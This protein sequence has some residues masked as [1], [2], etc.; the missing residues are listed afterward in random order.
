MN[1]FKGIMW[2]IAISAMLWVV[3]I[4]TSMA[5]VHDVDWRKERI[6]KRAKVNMWLCDRALN[7]MH[8]SK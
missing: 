6:E 3:I 5:I 8:T 2:G 7:E 1:A 4:L